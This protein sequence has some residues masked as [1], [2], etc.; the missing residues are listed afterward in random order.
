VELAETIFT[1]LGKAEQD[2]EP[3]KV[4]SHSPPELQCQMNDYACGFFTIHAIR[5][6]G[7]GEPLST[8]TNDQTDN[9]RSEILDLIIANLP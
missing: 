2:L 7:N 4:L 3:W 8:V 5:A 1:F 6:L 9:V